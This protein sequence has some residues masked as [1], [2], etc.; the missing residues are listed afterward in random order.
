MSVLPP[1][2]TFKDLDGYREPTQ[3]IEDY[4]PIS[5]LVG[6]VNSICKLNS[7]LPCHLTSPQVLGIRAY[8][9]WWVEGYCL[10]HYKPPEAQNFHGL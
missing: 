8:V 2:S 1:G 6:N 4:L 7:L 9:S 5:K 10:I 3:I